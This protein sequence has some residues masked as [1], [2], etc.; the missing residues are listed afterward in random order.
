MGTFS[1]PITLLDASGRHRERVEALVDTGATFSS[2]PTSLLERLG[3][4][5]IGT[6]R[7]RLASGQ[8]EEWHLGE[9][10]AELDGTQRPI[11]CFFG[12][13]GAPALIGAHALE[14]FLLTVDLVEQRLVPKEAYLA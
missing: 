13:P 5:P 12:P 4:R 7:V 6:V 1:H 8:E 2:F 14:A 10:R 11:L 9:V 3:V